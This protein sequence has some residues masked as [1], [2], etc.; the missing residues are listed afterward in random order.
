MLVYEDTV[1]EKEI[2]YC[3]KRFETAGEQVIKFEKSG[4]VIPHEE[5]L[6]LTGEI[7]TL[8]ST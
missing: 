3:D 1:G 7:N 8:F 4:E 2:K 6:S 5:S